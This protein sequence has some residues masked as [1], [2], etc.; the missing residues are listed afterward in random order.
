VGLIFA[1][2]ALLRRHEALE[3]FIY[4]IVFGNIRHL[5]EQ[6]A[7]AHGLRG[8]DIHHGG[9]F[10]FHQLGEIGQPAI[11]AYRRRGGFRLGF[12]GCIR[13]R[14]RTR[15]QGKAQHSGEQ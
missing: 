4:R 15:R 13:G 10:F 8:A 11:H 7:L 12:G 9:A 5:R 3:K 2:P 6:A 1:R 14:L